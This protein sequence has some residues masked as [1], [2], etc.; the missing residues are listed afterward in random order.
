MF[1]SV[2]FT[3]QYQTFADLLNNG[4]LYQCTLQDTCFTVS[5]SIYTYISSVKS[6]LNIMDQYIKRNLVPNNNIHR[7]YALQY[8]FQIHAHIN[9]LRKRSKHDQSNMNLFIAISD[10]LQPSRS[11]IKLYS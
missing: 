10:R 11:R 9:E 5:Y 6:V 1:H 7:L 3:E 4:R 8:P 2:H